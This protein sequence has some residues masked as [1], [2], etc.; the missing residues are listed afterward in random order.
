[1]VGVLDHHV[2]ERVDE[3]ADAVRDPAD[4]LLGAHPSEH[5]ALGRRQGAQAD[6]LETQLVRA[7]QAGGGL[8]RRQVQAPGLGLGRDLDLQ[9]RR[10]FVDDRA[11]KGTPRPRAG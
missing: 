8:E 6:P 2:A 4:E 5:V 10:P 3:R 11:A 9:G 1:L 7:V